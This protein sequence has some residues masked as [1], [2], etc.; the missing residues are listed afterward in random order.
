MGR[1]KAKAVKVKNKNKGAEKMML[2]LAGGDPEKMKAM[3]RAAN[4]AASNKSL[5]SQIQQKYKGKSGAQLEKLISNDQSIKNNI[6]GIPSKFNEECLNCKIKHP[7]E[8]PDLMFNGKFCSDACSQL[9]ETKRDLFTSKM[10]RFENRLCNRMNCNLRGTNRCKGCE[11]VVY[12]SSECHVNDWAENHKRE[13]KIFRYLK[14]KLRILS[15][16]DSD[17]DSDTD[18]DLIKQM[19]IKRGETSVEKVSMG[20]PTEPDYDSDSDMESIIDLMKKK[21]KNEV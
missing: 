17:S 1:R 21:K 19:S 5:Q 20:E 6:G 2:E 7:C 16:S 10:Q 3:M 18:T 14:P 11:M 9:F 15:S 12:C 13:C 4:A 8:I